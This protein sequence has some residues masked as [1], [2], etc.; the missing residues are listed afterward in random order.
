MTTSTIYTFEREFA[1][2]GHIVGERL[3]QKL[4]IPFYDSQ[5]VDLAAKNAG[6]NR[7]LFEGFDEK[8]TN[9]FLYSLVMGTYTAV[10]PVTQSPSLNISDRL[11]AEEAE[12]I[13]KAADDGPCVIV[14]RCSSYILRDRPNVARIF[15][16]AEMDFR[17]HHAVHDLGLP[18]NRIEDEIGKRDKKRSNYFNYYTGQKWESASSYD[19]SVSTSKLGIDG[20]VEMVLAYGELLERLRA[21]NS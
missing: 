2:A 11:F 10:N 1:S 13:R 20:A 16:T 4:G 3:A 21:E 12:I 6:V 15:V 14:G 18:E 7:K 9:S 5:I 8:P 19:L 17:I